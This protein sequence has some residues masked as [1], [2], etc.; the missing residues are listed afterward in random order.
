[1]FGLL[2]MISDRC[3]S[4]QNIGHIYMINMMAVVAGVSDADK[5]LEG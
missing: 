3:S 2:I 1:L 4:W 5:N